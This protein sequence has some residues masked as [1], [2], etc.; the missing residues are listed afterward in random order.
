[1][2]ILVTGD[3]ILPESAIVISNH[4]SVADYLLLVYLSRTC[5]TI[6]PQTNFFTWY[7][8]WRVP[9]IKTLLNMFRCDENWE[10]SKSWTDLIF[11]RVVTSEAPEWIVLFPEV[12]ILTPATSYLQNLQSEKYYLPKFTEVL[13]PRFSGL[14]NASRALNITSSEKFSK[15]YDLSINY[16]H[17]VSLLAIFSNAKS[18]EVKI[19]VRARNLN[20]FPQKRAKIEKWLEKVWIEKEKQVHNMS[21]QQDQPTGEILLVLDMPLTSIATTSSHLASN[22][23]ANF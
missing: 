14:Q 17:K 21:F 1:M 18:I 4:Q 8:L 22:G 12:N 23:W 6:H 20:R 15:L 13:Y 2:N 7:S 9:T 5:G 3:Q 16:S 11:K 10:L 19:H